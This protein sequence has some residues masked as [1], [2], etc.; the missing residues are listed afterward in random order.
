[1]KYDV[2]ISSKSEDYSFAEKVYEYLGTIVK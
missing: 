2:F 1:M